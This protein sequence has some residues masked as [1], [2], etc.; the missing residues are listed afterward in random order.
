MQERLKDISGFGHCNHTGSPG[1]VHTI[2]EVIDP[3]RIHNL[4]PGD[5]WA[6]QLADAVPE[7]CHCSVILSPP[8]EAHVSIGQILRHRQGLA[9]WPYKSPCMHSSDSS[10][11]EHNRPR[12]SEILQLASTRTNT[13][14][15]IDR[16]TLPGHSQANRLFEKSPHSRLWLQLSK[17]LFNMKLVWQA[18]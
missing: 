16:R 3:T 1:V 12:H 13:R 11:E 2:M 17:L 14:D 6:S 10:S 18:Q 5:V 4:L 15:A 8:K 7:L 9:I